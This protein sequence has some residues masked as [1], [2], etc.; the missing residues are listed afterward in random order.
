MNSRRAGFLVLLLF[1]ALLAAQAHSSVEWT[2]PHAPSHGCPVCLAGVWTIP[3]P[4]P[5]LH[6]LVE[7]FRT[8]QISSPST[9]LLEC[10]RGLSPR[11]PPAA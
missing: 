9:R 2:Q 5:M 3:A 6:T 1:L 7:V 8:E 4:A 10:V 11:A